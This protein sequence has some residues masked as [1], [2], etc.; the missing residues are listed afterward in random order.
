[1]NMPK[2]QF[3]MATQGENECQNERGTIQFCRLPRLSLQIS[4]QHAQHVAHY[5]K[6]DEPGSLGQYTGLHEMYRNH[7]D[8]HLSGANI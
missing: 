7:A 5:L 4:R 1:M 3:H 2:T 8:L 6:Y